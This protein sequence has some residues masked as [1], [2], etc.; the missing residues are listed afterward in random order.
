[1]SLDALSKEI[2]TQAEARAKSILEGAKAEAKSIHDE[3]VGRA[4]DTTAKVEAKATK[5]SEQISTELVAAAKQA[6]QKRAL[7]AR[8]EELDLTWDSV[9]NEVSSADLDGRED[10]LRGLIE[11]VESHTKEMIMRPVEI[12]RKYLSTSNFEMGKDIPGL[13]GFVLESKDGSV[14]LDYR[15]DSLLEDAWKSCMA[16]VNKVLFGE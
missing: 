14:V 15:F 4:A 12:D 10:I 8:R 1:M 9:K 5:D 7:V 13:G 6:N 16:S 11:G 2:I 3:A